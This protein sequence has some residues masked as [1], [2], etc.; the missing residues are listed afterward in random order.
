MNVIR[1]HRL[2]GSLFVFGLLFAPLTALAQDGAN[3][4]L[5]GAMAFDA[6]WIYRFGAVPY[7]LFFSL[8]PA[9]FLAAI[10]KQHAPAA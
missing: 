7:T 10:L 5:A 8:I 2:A 4:S 9:T 1:Y 3:W 6:P